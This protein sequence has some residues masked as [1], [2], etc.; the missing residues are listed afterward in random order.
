MSVD[1]A[2]LR[3]NTDTARVSPFA[4]FPQVL[5]PPAARDYTQT[6][7]YELP[8]LAQR[9]IKLTEIHNLS[10]LTVARRNI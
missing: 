8:V 1:L 6:P 5:A 4:P 9:A 3:R 2:L 10:G 7:A